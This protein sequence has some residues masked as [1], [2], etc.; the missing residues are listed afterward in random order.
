MQRERN[1][2]QHTLGLALAAILATGAAQAHQSGDVILRF[3]AT[4]TH[5]SDDPYENDM[6]WQRA[7]GAASNADFS[8]KLK[9]DISPALGATWMFADAFGVNLSW[10]SYHHKLRGRYRGANPKFADFN[11]LNMAS[12]KQQALDIGAVWYPLGAGSERLHPYVGVAT[13]Y[14]RV[15]SSIHR[16]WAQL[17]HDLIDENLANG[18]ITAANAD[19][20]HQAWDDFI[21]DGRAK[22]SE[23]GWKSH[24]GADFSLNEHWLLNAQ[25]GYVHSATNLTYWNWTLGAGFKF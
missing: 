10:N 9:N 8:L 12:F 16:D 3:G 13:T 25:M 18:L 6:S 24:V 14:T 5:L 7:T 15:K 22:D 4:G 17:E 21:A 20:R 19:V 23:W 1:F 2:S 11:R